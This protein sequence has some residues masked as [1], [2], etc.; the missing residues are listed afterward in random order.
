M[1][2]KILAAGYRL[3]HQLVW[4][5]CR[6]DR[7][8]AEWVYHGKG[9]LYRGPDRCKKRV[10]T[11]SSCFAGVCGGTECRDCLYHCRKISGDYGRNRGILSSGPA[12]VYIYLG[13]GGRRPKD[14]AA[15]CVE[16]HWRT[17]SKKGWKVREY[18]RGNGTEV[19]DEP[20]SCAGGHQTT[21]GDRWKRRG[22]FFT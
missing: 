11:M 3:Y 14:Q 6:M 1:S 16:P 8:P 10:K 18:H 12:E 19:S 5:R 21:Y 13:N 2:D 4:W 22:A 9:C 7:G 20:Y 17:K 15:S